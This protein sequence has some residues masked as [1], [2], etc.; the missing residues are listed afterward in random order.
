MIFSQF[1]RTTF[2]NTLRRKTDENCEPVFVDVNE[3]VVTTNRPK[4]RP[5]ESTDKLSAKKI[6][7]GV[8]LN[9]AGPA[10]KK[11]KPT[12]RKTSDK[13]A[14]HTQTTPSSSSPPPSL[15]PPKKTQ[16]KKRPRFILPAVPKNQSPRS[17]QPPLKRKKDETIEKSSRVLRNR[18]V[19]IDI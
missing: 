5:I 14:T 1:R 13:K 4:K 16:A 9:G 12:N 8:G 18:K 6:K 10:C 3:A 15:P 19:C 11:K 17:D 7:K 2:V